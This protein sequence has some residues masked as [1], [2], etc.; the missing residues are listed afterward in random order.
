[1]VAGHSNHVICAIGGFNIAKWRFA[2][3][4]LIFVIAFVN[5]G[6]LSLSKF[7]Y[8]YT[9]ISWKMILLC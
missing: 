5:I 9:Q 3:I 8:N 4:I 1:M 6:A 2:Q 7:A